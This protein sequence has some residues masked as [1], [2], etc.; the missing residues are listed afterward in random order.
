MIEQLTIKGFQAHKKLTI[1]LDPHITCIVGPNSAGKSSIVRALRWICLN[2]KPHGRVIHWALSKASVK[3]TVDGQTVL[4]KQGHGTNLYSLNGQVFK[5]FA[6][7]TPEPIKQLLNLEEVN[8]QRQHDQPFW[9]SLSPGQVSRELN[10]IVNLE[11]IDQSLS[12]IGAELRKARTVVDVIEERLAEARKQKE[13][14]QWIREV[15]VALVEI[16]Q[17]YD[18]FNGI[19][20][21]STGLNLL[22]SNAIQYQN[23]LADSRNALVVSRTLLK[24]GEKA[25]ELV[26]RRNA[27]CV[28][29]KNGE[30]AL[31]LSR[32]EIPEVPDELKLVQ[33]RSKIGRLKSI[34][35]LYEELEDKQ[36]VVQRRI[37]QLNELMTNLTK[38]MRMCP[39]CGQRIS[40]PLSAHVSTS[41]TNHQ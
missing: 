36:W 29:V 7:N 21:A 2:K 38:K 40:S 32:I 37:N 24:I 28:L 19:A 9:F 26:D 20:S 23:K 30:E 11:T 41:H 31:R 16:E 1:E 15:D 35:K 13:Q 12:N 33:A 14:L 22:V 6:S 39:L 4:R 10:S 5:A 34:I 18:H 8:F 3:L 17:K 25:Q 27:L